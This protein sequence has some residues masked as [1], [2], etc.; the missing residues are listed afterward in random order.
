MD[1]WRVGA[2]PSGEPAP[3]GTE[4]PGCLK[5]HPGQICGFGLGEYVGYTRPM[6]LGPGPMCLV[7]PR[8]MPEIEPGW[9]LKGL[10]YLSAPRPSAATAGAPGGNGRPTSAAAASAA[11]PAHAGTGSGARS[12]TGSGARSGTHRSGGSGSPP[13][14]AELTAPRLLVR[15]HCRRRT[16]SPRGTVMK[17]ASPGPRPGW[18]VDGT[19]AA[20]G[21]P[22]GDGSRGHCRCPH[23]PRGPYAAQPDLP[24]PLPSCRGDR[25]RKERTTSRAREGPCGHADHRHPREATH[26]QAST[27]LDSESEPLTHTA[28][29]E[30]DPSTQ[31]RACS[32][33]Q[34]PPLGAFPRLATPHLG[35]TASRTEGTSNPLQRDI[36]GNRGPHSARKGPPPGLP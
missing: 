15:S 21:P 29:G 36:A 27:G 23:T 10:R 19:T 1:V 5:G 11:A 24:A 3:L 9:P 7:L 22:P 2:G 6:C 26:R 30:A 33:S 25:P 8:L 28:S 13:A 18:R 32:N 20:H 4:G 12:G 16:P 17:A 35:A 31:G 14:A 34:P